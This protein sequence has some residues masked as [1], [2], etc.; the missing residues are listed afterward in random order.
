MKIFKMFAL[1]TVV[2][3][4]VACGKDNNAGTPG[5]NNTEIAGFDAIEKEWK[6][7]SVDGVANDFS[8]YISFTDGLFFLYQQV[9]S[10]D[11]VLY[12]GQYTVEGGVLN[13]TY[14]DGSEWKTAYTGGV[15]EDGQYLIL[16]SKEATPVTY[17][18][19]ACAIPEEVFDEAT[20]TRAEEIVPFL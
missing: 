3:F 1:A 7:I 13:G 18:Y 10:W 16:K 2:L 15:S 19:E 4:T 12:E 9:Y 20:G 6:L 8:V 17:K 14:T 5:G 11:Y